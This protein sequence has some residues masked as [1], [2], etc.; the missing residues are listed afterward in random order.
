MGTPSTSQ[1]LPSH[2]GGAGSGFCSWARGPPALAASAFPQGRE[3]GEPLP[4]R[5]LHPAT[6]GTELCEPAWWVLDHTARPAAAL[7]GEDAERDP[8]GDPDSWNH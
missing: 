4:A 1:H 7:P 3:K 5:R 6:P 8:Q 2:R